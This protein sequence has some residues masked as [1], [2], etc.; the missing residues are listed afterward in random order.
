[1]LSLKLASREEGLTILCIGA[2]CDD[3]EIGCGGTLLRLLEEYPVKQVRW[4]VFTSTQERAK[5]ARSCAEA[6]LVNVKKKEIMIKSFRDSFLFDS[7]AEVKRSME[8]IRK[9]FQPDVVFTHHRKDLHQDHRLLA[10]LTWN[11]FR[12]HLILEYEIPKYD[13]DL[14][15]PNFFVS[16][17]KS[18]VDKKT[19]LLNKHYLSQSAKHWFDPELFSGLMRLRGMECASSTR[20]AEAFHT[21]K[22][23]L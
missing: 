16:L 2:H 17:D 6:F 23:T 9:N 13:A 10:E 11:A 3:I 4:I 20:Y 5:E 7:A 15:S 19:C 12:N 18:V 14:G 21:R 22:T 8:E 1:M